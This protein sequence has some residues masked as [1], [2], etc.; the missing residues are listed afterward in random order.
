MRGYHVHVLHSLPAIGQGGGAE[1]KMNG[2]PSSGFQVGE[3]RG[4]QG[5]VHVQ[6]EE[7]A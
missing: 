3:N 7:V 5:C 1:Q 2:L 6:R 4:D